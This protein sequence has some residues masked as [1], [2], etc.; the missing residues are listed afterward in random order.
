MAIGMP[1]ATISHPST[2]IENGIEGVV[3][4]DVDELRSKIGQL[5]DDRDAA[6]RMG[7]AARRKLESEFPVEKFRS[8]WQ[9]LAGSLF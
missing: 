7:Q 9:A 4:S 5:M 2:P 1:V 6:M 3:G 8:E